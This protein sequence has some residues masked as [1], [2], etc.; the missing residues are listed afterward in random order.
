MSALRRHPVIAFFVLA[1]L[2]SWS[3]LPLGGFLPAGPLLAAVVVIAL[4]QGRPGFRRLGSRLIRWR[5]RWTCYALA[6]GVPLAVHALTIAANVGLGSGAPSLGQLSPVSGV[7]VVFAVRLVDPLDGPLGEEPGWRGF[8]Q[9]ALLQ[10]RTPLRAT[11]VMGVLVAGWHLP[12][13]LLPQFGAGPVDVVSDS[14]GSFAVTFWYAWLLQRASGSVLL[15]LIA[16]AVEG[17]LQIELYWSDGPAA[18][19]TS[20][21]YAAVWCAVAVVLVVADRQAWWPQRVPA[22]SRSRV[23]SV[24]TV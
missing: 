5:V 12:L 7:L 19:R 2:L 9:P 14:L 1:Y 11:V 8:A 3:L 22:T 20:A 24:S 10:G 21:L 18:T 15:T 17:S 23:G 4:T 6:V 13:W 16:H